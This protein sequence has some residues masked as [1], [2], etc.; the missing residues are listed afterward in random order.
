M[1]KWRYAKDESTDQ[2]ADAVWMDD[3]QLPVVLWDSAYGCREGDAVSIDAVGLSVAG[4]EITVYPNPSNGHVMVECATDRIQQL[5]IVD[6]FGRCVYALQD[7]QAEAVSLDLAF[8][9]KGVYMVQVRLEE[10]I[11]NRKLIIK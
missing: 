3:V 2:G 1:L 7:V 4:K 10:G 8:L 9:P 5:S 6:I 11:E